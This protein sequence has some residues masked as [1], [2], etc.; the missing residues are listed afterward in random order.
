MISIV[1]ALAA[2]VVLVA[3]FLCGLVKMFDQTFTFADALLAAALAGALSFIPTIGSGISVFGVLAVVYWRSVDVS[4][5][6]VMVLS[7]LAHFAAALV[8]YKVFL[9]RL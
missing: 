7:F 9:F 2:Y 6:T 4:I 8:V 1:V 3:A 5:V